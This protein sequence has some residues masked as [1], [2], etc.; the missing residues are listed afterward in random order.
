V[1][2]MGWTCY[3]SVPGG[4]DESGKPTFQ[5]Q[6]AFELFSISSLI[7]LYFSATALIM[8]LAILTSRKQVEDFNR[9]LPMKLL[10]GLSSLFV[11]IVSMFISFIA[12][13]YFVL[14]DKYT[15]SGLFFYLYIAIC[16]PIAYY[17]YVQLPLYIDLLKVIWKK[18][19]P[20]SIKGVKL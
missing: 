18:V 13:H 11:A 8:F 15:K 6:P 5:G 14:T 4:N 2:L 3:H 9:D 16:L 7:G 1:G 19:P 10:F 12:G 20:P 17:G